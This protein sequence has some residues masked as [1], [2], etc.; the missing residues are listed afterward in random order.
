[1]ISTD[2]A[3]RFLLLLGKDPAQTWFRTIHGRQGANKRRNGADLRGFDATELAADSAHGAALC[4]VIG[5]ASQATGRARTVQDSDVETMPA[6][7]VE[8]D[9]LPIEEQLTAWQRLWLPEPTLIMTTGGKSAHC[10]WRLREPAP[11]D[12]WR[13]ATVQLIKH[14]GSDRSICNPSRVMRLAGSPYIDKATGKHTGARAEIVHEAP[15]ALYSME[16]VLAAVRPVEP[17]PVP[18]PNSPGAAPA[19]SRDYPPRSLE[20]VR[21]AL[22]F[23]PPILPDNNQRE[24]FRKL[25][26]SLLVAVREAGS[27]DAMALALLQEH[28]PLV[29]DAPTYLQTEPVKITARSFWGMAKDHGWRPTGEAG[30]DPLDGF[31]VQEEQP[32]SDTSEPSQAPSSPDRLTAEQCRERLIEAH[33]QGIGGSELAVLIS[34]LAESSDVYLLQLREMSDA[35]ALEIERELAAEKEEV[36]M[37]AEVDRQQIAGAITLAS[38]L[39]QS[40]ADAIRTRCDGMPYSELLLA[41]VFITTMGGLTK[42]GTKVNGNPGTRFIVPTNLFTAVVADSGRKKTPLITAMVNEPLE[43]IR[44]ELA[45]QHSRAMAQW[46]EASQ[47]VK[48]SE[49][50]DAPKPAYAIVHDYTGEALANLLQEHDRLGLALLVLRDELAGLFGSLNAYRGGRGGDEQLLLELFDGGAFNSL[51]IRGDRAYERSHVAILGN[52]QPAI[53]TELVGGNDP[54]GKW[55]R[56]IFCP[57][58]ERIAPLP[59]EVSAEQ[60]QQTREAVT[61]LQTV[62]KAVY[63]LPPAEYRL[64]PA[65]IAHFAQFELTQQQQNHAAELNTVQA[66][67]GKA[68]GKVLRVAGLLHIV[69]RVCDPRMAEPHAIGLATLKNAILL[70]ETLNLWAVDFHADAAAEAVGGIGNLMRRVHNASACNGRAWVGWR[71]LSRSLG[72]RQRSRIDRNAFEQTV[73]RLAGDDRQTT[74]KDRQSRQSGPNPAIRYGESRL[75]ERRCLQYRAIRDP[76]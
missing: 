28:S 42:V 23:I 41:V 60:E 21:E 10:Y 73:H 35:A 37:A 61:L 25:A 26:W 13:A 45:Q 8:W 33:R 18:A 67:H 36:R 76:V 40:V 65:A 16:E 56:F 43:Q 47:G 12:K 4:V 29:G 54:S 53:L 7:F 72:R 17:A 19:A 2:T 57:L 9:N 15:E 71:D 22:Q 46:Q 44:L 30:P 3:R 32:G 31:E 64:E 14:C 51:R 74:D 39:P 20:E 50:P 59:T 48:P 55:A 69:M 27:N 11:P 66:L 34:K 62:A 63:A 70:V 5:N 52:I 58:T 38:L 75:N 24:T 49:R 68:A 6:L 1:V